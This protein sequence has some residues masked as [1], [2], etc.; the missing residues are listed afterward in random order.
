MAARD[1]DEIVLTAVALLPLLR[2]SQRLAEEALR[3]LGVAGRREIEIDHV[4]ELVERAV[5]VQIRPLATDLDIGLVDA[6]T[7]RLRS[8]PLP[9][10]PFLDLGRVSPNP[11]IDRGV[12]DRDAAARSSSLRGRGS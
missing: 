10:H 11:A 1:L 6:L 8:A 4:P 3:R 2:S 9:A 5:A 12:V 7:S